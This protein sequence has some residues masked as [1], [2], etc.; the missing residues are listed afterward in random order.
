MRWTQIHHL[1]Y[2]SQGGRTDLN[3]LICLCGYH[4]RLVHEDGWRITG[5]PNNEITWITPNGQ[6]WKPHRLM[7]GPIVR[8]HPDASIPPHLRTTPAPTSGQRRADLD[9]S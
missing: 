4:H 5:D 3:N 1:T 6:P 9:T 7:V 2:W 8:P